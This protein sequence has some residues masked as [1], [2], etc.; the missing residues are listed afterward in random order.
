MAG[1]I[2]KQVIEDIRF[3]SDIV[4]I[5]DAYITLPKK[6]AAIKA[7]CPF[8]KEKTPSFTVNRQ[9]Q[10]FHCFGCGAGGDVFKFIMMHEQADFMGA[11]RI[12][13]ERAGIVLQFEK[14]SGP[15]DERNLLFALHEES[16][17]LYHKTLLKSAEAQEARAYLAKRGLTPDTVESFMIGYAPNQFDFIVNWARGKKHSLEK[18]ELAG[19]LVRNTERL[20]KSPF[21]DRFR[22]RVMFPIRNEQGRIVGFSG[23]TLLQDKTVAKY[24]NSPETPIFRKSHI[25]YALDRGRRDIVEKR[26]A[27]VCEGQIDVIRCHQ[28]GFTTAVAAQ[29]TAFTEDHARIL[30]RYADSVALVFDSDDAGQNAAVKAA[31]VFMQAGMAVRIA[32]LPPGEDPDTLILKQGPAAFQK[33][34]DA[35]VPAIDF[36][37]NLL[38]SR[39]DIRSEAGLMRVVQAVLATISQS[40]DAVQRDQL[41]EQAANRLLISSAT[42]HTQLKPLLKQAAARKVDSAAP[43]SAAPHPRDELLLAEH[44]AAAPSLVGLV[45][46][47][48]PLSLLTDPLCRRFVEAVIRSRRDG[49]DLMQAMADLDDPER[50]LAAFAA[51]LFNA[52]S[53]APS[54]ES[55]REAI[56]GLILILWRAELIRRRKEF[57]YH[58]VKE[59][60]D[61]A[62]MSPECKQLTE[63]IHRLRRW[64][65]GEPILALYAGSPAGASSQ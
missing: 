63:H 38:I 47:Y 5:I 43:A 34:I 54:E 55:R 9:R 23:R 45:E 17:A 26:E 20:D 22:H 35:A 37:I 48:L 60:K 27:I 31:A 24:V 33:A 59:G 12:L 44:L 6:G 50:H 13:A 40:P 58:S 1:I 30:H 42:L 64:D 16:A 57:E 29:G 32:S 19:L 25:L 36:Q 52:P 51:G 49:A 28:A 61:D 10:T 2:P 14:S 65:T 18:L 39:E 4:D 56:Q 8:H 15:P 7:L 11:V 21:F 53:K 3:R 41:V 46:Q 62:V